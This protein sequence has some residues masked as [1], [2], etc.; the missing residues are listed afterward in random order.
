MEVQSM[1]RWYV[2]HTHAISEI[3]AVT[4]S[5]GIIIWHLRDGE[6]E[7]GTVKLRSADQLRKWQ[8]EGTRRWRPDL[9]HGFVEA[10][11]DE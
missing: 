4:D 7:R 2:I 10:T 8:A 6:G 1:K 11:A 9:S 5:S 3:N